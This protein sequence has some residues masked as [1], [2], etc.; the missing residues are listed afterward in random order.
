MLRQVKHDTMLSRIARSF[1]QRRR[2][3]ITPINCS[4]NVS[5]PRH[6]ATLRVSSCEKFLV[7][8][9]PKNQLNQAKFPLVWL[10]DN[11]QCRHCFH[12]E[13][14]R[15]ILDLNQFEFDQKLSS[16]SVNES[17]AA[18]NLK[19]A[20]GHESQFKL[21]YFERH[22]FDKETAEEYIRKEYRLP[23]IPWSKNN[24]GFQIPRYN[25]EEILY[26]PEGAEVKRW[27]TGL[28]QDG[29]A[30]LE[31][32]KMKNREDLMNLF[33][34]ATFGFQKETHYGRDFLI[35]NRLSDITNVAY[36]NGN[37]QLH[38][39][40]P[41]YDY[42]PGVTVLHYLKQS[43]EGGRSTLADGFQIAERL[44]ATDPEA[45]EILSTVPVNWVDKGIEN[46]LKFHKVHI[47]PVI[48]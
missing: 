6:L 17:G 40:L 48:G 32:P 20:D 29:M 39:D 41:Y 16:Y 12:P 21:D 44:R 25:L 27:L 37:L 36:L 30:I 46:G 19:W 31:N 24:P 10:R 11:C 43:K 45:F 13:V 14:N 9:E 5:L 33:I 8:D 15:R 23:K 2:N 28:C 38:T 3:Q 18:V 35:Q 4:F 7:V 42:V 47:T 34:K 22:K 26:N 1:V